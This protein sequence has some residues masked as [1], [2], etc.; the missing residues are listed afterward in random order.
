M[1]KTVT[2]EDGREL[3][4]N[5]NKITIREWRDLFKP[6]APDDHDLEIVGRIVGLAVQEAEALGFED[7]ARIKDAVLEAVRNPLA[8]PD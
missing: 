8:K 4:I 1:S 3:A 6:D 7:W 2:L 5:L